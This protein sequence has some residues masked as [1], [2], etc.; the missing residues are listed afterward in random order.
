MT[1]KSI[2]LGVEILEERDV[3]SAT[4]LTID[5][6]PDNTSLL[7]STSA[8]YRT[9]DT[10]I[11]AAE[12][13]IVRAFQTWA[14]VANI[15]FGL[16]TGSGPGGLTPYADP[17]QASVIHISA[18][19]LSSGVLAIS[20]PVNNLSSLSG[21]MFINANQSFSI[22]GGAGR[23]DL[24]TTAVHEV[25]IL[26]GLRENSTPSSVMYSQYAGVRTGL[27]AGDITA[28]QGRYGV[29]T[30]DDF[31]G[32]SGNS[33]FATAA[34]F[35]MNTSLI[36]ANLLTPQDV[37]YYT[38]NVD[39]TQGPTTIT[40]QTSGISLLTA[41][42]TVY[43][44]NGNVIGTTSASDARNGNLT[45]ILSNYPQASG[46]RVKIESASTGVSGLGAY[47]LSITNA[48]TQVAT[49]L[50]T[51]AANSLTLT[52]ANS[53][54]T[55]SLISATEVDTYAVKA[56]Y[57]N[58]SSN[59]SSFMIVNVRSQ[60]NLLNPQV[61]VYDQNGNLMKTDLLVQDNGMMTIQVRNVQRDQ[62]LT[63]KVS[64][65]SGAIGGYGLSFGFSATPVRSSVRT[66]GTLNAVAV[67]TAGLMQVTQQ[68]IVH[69]VLSAK[70]V[71]G[72]TNTA[73]QLTIR[74]S[75][76]QVVKNIT[77]NSGSGNSVD[78]LL[79]RGNY[80]VE[81]K[82]I[83]LNGSA[84]V[85]VSYVLTTY[86]V[87]NP[88]AVTSEDPTVDLSATPPPPPDAT[89]ELAP[90]APPD[91]SLPALIWDATFWWQ[92]TPVGQTILY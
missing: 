19:P 70:T 49:A 9:F 64:S 37:D 35:P 83:S 74:N 42:M 38:F 79:A 82:A 25:G 52:S 57:N 31:S 3:P 85:P 67:S 22:A 14:N 58:N 20:N 92:T 41:K 15:D 81:I 21:D 80:S 91:A 7:G 71:D 4:P 78:V 69:F 23:Y 6:M 65:A 72:S 55:G 33:T 61:V 47:Q 10:S 86:V 89:I 28:I 76:N 40:L 5:F 84:V 50:S 66:S 16:L 27:S 56:S 48:S 51:D 11:D 68:Q 29:R 39:P 60:T 24:Y 75:L 87:S 44:P 34:S 1:R 26:L 8:L 32:G 18:L 36:S 90:D 73:L 43:D 45:L 12:K 17:T 88:I 62:Q 30:A 53:A 13:E 46:Y 63:V 77:V 59:L 2:K 54:Y